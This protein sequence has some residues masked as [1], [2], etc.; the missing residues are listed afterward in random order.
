MPTTKHSPQWFNQ[1]LRDGDQ[2]I[3]RAYQAGTKIR[4]LIE[5]K[6][7]RV[8]NLLKEI[9]PS[10][11]STEDQISLVAVG[12]YGRRELHPKSDIDLLILIAPYHKQQLS[13]KI[14][15]LITFLWDA[16]LD[17]GHSVR[18]P[19]ECVQAAQQDVTVMTNLLETRLLIGC[20]KL[21][22]TTLDLV[23]PEQFWSAADFF[24]TK[25]KE[26]QQRHRKYHDTAYKLE[27]NIKES[28]GGLRD[29]Q[30]IAWVA[31]RHF[32]AQSLQDLVTHDFLTSSELEEL[33]RGQD[34]LWKVRYL[35][36][37]LTQ[38]REDRLLFDLQ[39]DLAHAFGY[40]DDTKNLAVEQFMQR[41]FR[42]VMRL[43]RLNEMLLQLFKEVILHKDHANIAQVINQRFVNHKGFLDV[44]HPNVFKDFPPAIFEVFN[45]LALNPEIEGVRAQ[46]IRLIRNH[47]YLINDKFREDMMARQA[48]IEIWRH[49]RGI[50]HNLR[51]MSRYGVLAAYLSAFEHIVGRM[52]YDLFHV[53][54]VDEHSLFVVRNLRRMMIVK[55]Q[56]ELP[57]CSQIASQ[58]RKPEVLFLAGFFHDIAK[59]RGGDH[60]EL[61]ATEATNFCEQHSLNLDDT[62]LIAWLV[63]HHLLMS[64]TAQRK[65]LS[66][67]NVIHEFAALVKNTNTLNHLFLLTVADIRG[68]NPELWNSWKDSLL[69]ELYQSTLRALRRG[70]DKPIE[71]HEYLEEAKR[72]ALAILNRADIKANHVKNIWQDFGDDYFLRHSA[73]EIAW[74]TEAILTR[75]KIDTPLVLVRQETE[76]GA[77]EVFIFTPDHDNLF[78]LFT[79]VLGRVATNI[80]DARIITSHSGWAVDTFLILEENGATINDPIRLAEIRTALELALST[81]DDLP[82]LPLRR[83]PRELRHFNVPLDVR[84]FQSYQGPFTA[85]EVI[86]TDR[87]GLLSRVGRAFV[88]SGIRVHNARIATVG[89]R[90]EDIF[91]ISHKD[92]QKP[93]NKAA[94]AELKTAISNE[95]KQNPA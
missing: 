22:Q 95:L 10:F 53:Y 33:L 72:D 23:T 25:L 8:D 50:T 34:F 41:Y 83:T 43:Q 88:A 61:G 62:R 29:I 69:T 30:M 26:Q 21:Y 49:P 65:D 66:D 4:N 6:V 64:I 16:K 89:E 13:S 94:I 31:K 71:E 28:P 47:L 32:A 15:Q 90:A 52:Q 48:F 46:T 79:S 1:S 85:V 54:T 44:S 93:I 27:P 80:V 57:L 45:L 51:R 75:H 76:R 24:Q 84:I 73:D 91:V 42:N 56:H 2:A 3:H 35:L 9:W 67:P 40:L 20:A 70:L 78:A 60:S 18:T 87:P 55:H 82:E 19:D 77:S 38:R 58:I 12:G 36:H 7:T 5:L 59:G 37:H 81:P 14:E 11:F 17:I 63:R 39:R 92:K 74:H 68:T 86:A